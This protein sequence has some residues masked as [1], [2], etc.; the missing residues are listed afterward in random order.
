MLIWGLT[1]LIFRG[2]IRG[3]DAALDGK[4]ATIEALRI[5]L[6]EKAGMSRAEILKQERLSSEKLRDLTRRAPPRVDLNRTLHLSQVKKKL[7]NYALKADQMC[8]QIVAEKIATQGLSE[9]D[10]TERLSV[11]LA[12]DCRR[13]H[14][15]VKGLIERELGGAQANEFARE[16]K[17]WDAYNWSTDLDFLLTFIRRKKARLWDLANRITE[18]DLEEA[19]VARPR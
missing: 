16:Y 1:W 17:Q 8:D 13:W 11:F 19:P 7:R 14:T 3:K 5:Q 10:R 9:A 18:A 15:D 12:P 4:N 2:E 6:E